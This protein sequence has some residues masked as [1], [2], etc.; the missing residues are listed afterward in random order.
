[1]TFPPL[2]EREVDGLQR[3]GLRASMLPPPLVG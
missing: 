3:I 1:V 2:G